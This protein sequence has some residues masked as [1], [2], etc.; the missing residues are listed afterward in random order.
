MTEN[1]GL[2]G[3]VLYSQFIL[4]ELA[5][6]TCPPT[7]PGSVHCNTNSVTQL[8]VRS[9]PYTVKEAELKIKVKEVRKLKRE[10]KA[11]Y[12]NLEFNKSKKW[13]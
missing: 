1:Y 11:E 2:S 12:Y 5:C 6:N 8:A 4:N 13:Y 9:C 3:L 7:T 10:T